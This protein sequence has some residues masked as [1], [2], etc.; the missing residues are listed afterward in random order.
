MNLDIYIDP[1]GNIS[2]TETWCLTDMFTC[3]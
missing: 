1:L 2:D 3:D